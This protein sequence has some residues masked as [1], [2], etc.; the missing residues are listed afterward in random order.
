MKTESSNRIHLPPRFLRFLVEKILPRALQRDYPGALNESYRSWPQFVPESLAVIANG[1]RIQAI[2]A[3]NKTAFVAEIGALVFCFAAASLA[4]PL[5]IVVGTVLA[6]LTLRDAYTHSGQGSAR[7]LPEDFTGAGDEGQKRGPAAQYY[8]DSAG[9]AATAAVFLLASQ[10]LMWTVSPSLALPGT[11]LFHG[12]FVCL[13]LLA[14]LR[15]VLRPMSGGKAPFKGSNMSAAE[16]HKMTWR[17]NFLW[18]TA[19][20]GTIVTNPGAM[21]ASIPGHDLL[22]VFIPMATFIMW[23]R[24]QQD[25]FTR[26]SRIETVWGDW[27]EKE[28]ARKRENL[29]KGVDKQDPLYRGYIGLQALFFL[30]LGMPLA[31]GLWPWLA[32]RYADVD[33]FRLGF[34][35]GAFGTLMLSWNYVKNSN[36]AAAR[37]LQ[38]E[39]DAARASPEKLEK[40]PL[41][42]L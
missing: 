6:A 17:L 42:L 7:V 25:A 34:N 14:A 8:L 10:A 37:A 40:V 29:L 23:V 41:T 36:E 22:L 33:F 2:G 28:L 12:A 9:D 15:M 24:L 1:Y 16:I 27:K 19:C 4:L 30:L 20:F 3:F 38:K 5:W 13:P 35:L 26:D 11:P 39:I 32:G 21:P 31:A 18:M